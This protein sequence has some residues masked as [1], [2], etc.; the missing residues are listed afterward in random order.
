MPASRALKKGTFF[1]SGSKNTV[2]QAPEK[3][4]VPFFNGLLAAASGGPTL[5]RSS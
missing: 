1:I 4:N 2:N 5:R 3:K